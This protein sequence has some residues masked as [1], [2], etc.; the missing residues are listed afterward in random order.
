[1]GNT[2]E[3][4]DRRYQFNTGTEG[5]IVAALQSLFDQHNELIRLFRIVLEQMPSDD[6]KVVLRAD[7][8]PVGQ[9]E[10]QYNAPTIEEVATNLTRVI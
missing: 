5:E 4:I 2:D 8:T 7:K 6:Y 3:Q 1:M 10:R 9:H